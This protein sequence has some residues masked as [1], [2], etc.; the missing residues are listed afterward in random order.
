M[1]GGKMKKLLVVLLAL[2]MVCIFSTASF[3]LFSPYVT[4]GHGVITGAYVS[5]NGNGSVLI[6]AEYGF[7]DSLAICGQ[8]VNNIS[9]LDVKY[10]LNPNLAF[11]GGLMSLDVGGPL[12][13]FVGVNGDVSIT[14]DF[15]LIG[16]LNATTVGSDLYFL[17]E[18]GG[19]YNITQQLDIRGGLLGAFGNGVSS[20]AAIEL[21]VGFTF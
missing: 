6:G 9:K 12:N 19:K 11:L 7:T 15:M 14:K 17:Y 20:N 16:E 4:E 18:A 1:E 5:N 10:Q 13:L 2:T 8:N 21:G 3:G